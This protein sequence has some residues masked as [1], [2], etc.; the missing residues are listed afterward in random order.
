V[1]G[2]RGISASRPRGRAGFSSRRA[3][4]DP[5]AGDHRSS[6]SKAELSPDEAGRLA[7]RAVVTGE[8]VRAAA[9]ASCT[10]AGAPCG[11]ELDGPG[12]GPAAPLVAELGAWSRSRLVATAA[13]AA[14]RGT[15]IKLVGRA[16]TSER[17]S[18]TG[19]LL[20][21]APVLNVGRRLVS[22]VWPCFPDRWII[23]VDIGT[24]ATTALVED[25]PG[26]QQGRVSLRGGAPPPLLQKPF[27]GCVVAN[28]AGERGPRHWRHRSSK[29]KAE[30]SPEVRP[31]P[32]GDVPV[33]RRNGT[34][35]AAAS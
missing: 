11:A 17:A 13:W 35:A 22:P 16:G 12:L 21:L 34:S 29:S 8:T 1:V 24:A 6:E 7:E 31:W 3:R 18:S 32:P 19:F 9:A 23:V 33:V 2:R 30:L 20:G 26:D 27:V 28:I 15:P 4:P 5:I 10:G 25:R 14:A